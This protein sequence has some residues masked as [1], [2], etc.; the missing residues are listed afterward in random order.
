MATKYYK[1]MFNTGLSWCVF[2]RKDEINRI[3]QL[4]NAKF[5]KWVC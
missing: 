5:V 3:E 2:I 1:A 4:Y